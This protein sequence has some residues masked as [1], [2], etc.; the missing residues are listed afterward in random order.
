MEKANANQNRF[1][2][3]LLKIEEREKTLRRKSNLKLVAV[4]LVMIGGFIGYQQFQNNQKELD[5]YALDNLTPEKVTEMFA[6]SQEAVIVYH[7]EIP[8]ILI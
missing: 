2:E 6:Y 5:R 3:Y 7:P 8:F 4:M 1:E